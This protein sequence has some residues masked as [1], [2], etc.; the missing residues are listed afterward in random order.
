MPAQVARVDVH[1]V[2]RDGPDA[3]HVA[4]I[5][6]SLCAKL[7]WLEVATRAIE[8]GAEC[9]Q[10]REKAIVLASRRGFWR[11]VMHSG[12]YGGSAQSVK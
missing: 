9:I 11:A 12:G 1:G 4:V 2:R 8:G 10:L 6:E 7:P 5:S 3:P